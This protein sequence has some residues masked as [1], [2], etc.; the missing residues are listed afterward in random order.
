MKKFILY[1]IANR[2]DL[3]KKL[4]YVA[5]STDKYSKT[6]FYSQTI[7]SSYHIIINTNSIKQCEEFIKTINADT[8]LYEIYYKY[9]RVDR[10]KEIVDND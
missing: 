5:I 9:K 10:I 1:L 7:Y 4:G 8:K 6:L 2:L 3:N